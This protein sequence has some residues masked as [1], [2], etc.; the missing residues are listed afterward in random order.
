MTDVLECAKMIITEEV[1]RSGYRV[2]RILLFGSR[3][4]GEA[5]PDSDWDFF[6][7]TDSELPYPEQR[8]IKARIR[9]RFVEAGFWG[10]VFVQSEEA[11]QKKKANTG[12]LTY[13]VLK[14]GVEL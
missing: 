5:R 3:A 8:E 6:V 11:V 9:R 13:Y 10:D 12:F 1:E 7:V 4:R 14:E 2:R